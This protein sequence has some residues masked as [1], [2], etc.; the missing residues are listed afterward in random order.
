MDR[1]IRVKDIVGCK[2]SGMVPVGTCQSRKHLGGRVLQKANTKHQ[3]SSVLVQ[4]A[5]KKATS[6]R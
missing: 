6:C 1:L 5:G 2:K 3:S 4:P